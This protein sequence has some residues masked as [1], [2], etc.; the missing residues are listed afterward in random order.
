[1]FEGHRYNKVRDGKDGTVYWRCSRDR[2]CPGRAVTVHSRI[3]K[4]NNKH[5]HNPDSCVKSGQTLLSAAQLH[6]LN[7]L[8]QLTGSANSAISAVVNSN[9]SNS[10]N[11]N[12][13]IHSSSSNSTNNN[14]NHGIN[15]A[16][17]GANGNGCVGGTNGSSL[18]SDLTIAAHQQLNNLTHNGLPSLVNSPMVTMAALLAQSGGNAMAAVAAFLQHQAAAT[19]QAHNQ[20]L[21]T[22]SQLCSSPNSVRLFSSGNATPTSGSM[23]APVSNESLSN[24]HSPSAQAT[25]TAVAL[26]SL[27]GSGLLCSSML[28]SMPTTSPVT[29]STT[30]TGAGSTSSGSSPS[31]QL[32]SSHNH[33][34]A[35]KLPSQDQSN[36]SP[37]LPPKPDSQTSFGSFPIKSND[38]GALFGSTRCH[39]PTTRSSTINASRTSLTAP[40][41]LHLTLGLNHDSSNST[42]NIS[43]TTAS[44]INQL[45]NNTPMD[46]QPFGTSNGII[47]HNSSAAADSLNL[48]GHAALSGKLQDV[49]G[50]P[51]LLGEA[52]KYITSSSQTSASLGSSAVGQFSSSP[53]S[54]DS[55]MA[56]NGNFKTRLTPFFFLFCGSVQLSG[57]LLHCSRPLL[58]VS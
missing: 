16:T 6:Q 52:L 15:N 36:Y 45:L 3:K 17:N 26:Q 22:T 44:A 33:L 41:L 2:Q 48:L 10:H 4:A 38:N 8:T 50:L 29:P 1:V 27:L 46:T 18:S 35:D 7:S 49:L 34:F 32:S 9:N 37:S 43:T 24:E 30:C 25:A 57:R 20:L 13:H 42:G 11:H 40:E 31:H 56:A 19:Q 53:S 47:N 12:A 23:T 28:D 58:I 5:N 39:S 21:S 51:A 54:I 55:N 14:H